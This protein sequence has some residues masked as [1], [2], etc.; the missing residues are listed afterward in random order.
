MAIVEDQLLPIRSPA[1]AY[2]CQ[3]CDKDLRLAGSKNT[4]ELIYEA[5]KPSMS[6]MNSNV[7]STSTLRNSNSL[8]DLINSTNSSQQLQ[9]SPQNQIKSEFKLDKDGLMLAYKYFTSSTLT[10]RLCG[11]TQMNVSYILE[12]VA[13]FFK[14]LKNNF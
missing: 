4:T 6:L 3:L 1:I 8:N 2:M 11:V 7:G 5:F 13:Y 10:I 12:D 9:S 14:V